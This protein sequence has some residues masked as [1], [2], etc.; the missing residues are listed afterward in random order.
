MKR[1]SVQSPKKLSLENILQP[2]YVDFAL[3]AACLHTF[4]PV[5][6][7]FV[8]SGPRI[9]AAAEPVLPDVPQSLDVND[10]L[11][12]PEVPPSVGLDDEGYPQG[13]GRGYTPAQEN[14]LLG[15]SV[16]LT[17]MECAKKY[18]IQF[19]ACTKLDDGRDA[20]Y[21]QTPSAGYYDLATCEMIWGGGQCQC[22]EAGSCFYP[23]QQR[24]AKGMSCLDQ[25]FFFPGESME[26][27]KAGLMTVG[28][29]CCKSKDESSNACGFE[30]MASDLGLSDLAMTSLSVASAIND[31]TGFAGTSIA[32]KHLQLLQNQL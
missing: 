12:L 13:A 3:L 11:N 22:D 7:S 18:G 28:N 25:I 6:P 32:E 29:N 26:C 27:R 2:R 14:P 30:N 17:P 21:H 24:E 4:G 8:R 10:L 15:K 1:L 23:G 9:A 19:C 5:L 31:L 20:C 16:I